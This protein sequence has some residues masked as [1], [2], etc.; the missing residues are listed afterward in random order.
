M[1][2]QPNRVR[3]V[4]QRGPKVRRPGSRGERVPRASRQTGPKANDDLRRSRPRARGLEGE[5]G[6]PGSRDGATGSRA[7]DLNARR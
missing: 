5:P 6:R 1:A 7:R 2:F 3:Q 4:R